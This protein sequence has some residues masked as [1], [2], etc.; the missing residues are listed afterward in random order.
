[1]SKSESE[2]VSVSVSVSPRVVRSSAASRTLGHGSRRFCRRLVHQR[3]TTDRFFCTCLSP[4]YRCGDGGGSRAGALRQCV[5]AVGEVSS[6]RRRPCRPSPALPAV[7]PF[8]PPCP[9][10]RP[11]P[12]GPRRWLRR[13]LRRRRRLYVNASAGRRA[14]FSEQS[15]RRR[16]RAL[17]SS[18]RLTHVCG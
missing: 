16:L 6:R 9:A 12:A 10:R 11:F 18:R 1:M 5:R 14:P 4:V 8:S 17:V 7:V 13:R 3:A 2:S 15:A